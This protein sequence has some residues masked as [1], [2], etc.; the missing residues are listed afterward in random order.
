[1][2]ID[3]DKKKILDAFGFN[4]E[5]I[6]GEGER[7]LAIYK[8]EGTF[9]KALEVFFGEND[10]E[11]WRKLMAFKSVTEYF[12]SPAMAIPIAPTPELLLEIMRQ[13]APKNKNV[14]PDVDEYG[15][16]LVD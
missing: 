15:N 11:F 3:H 7:L 16:P 4:K 12:C 9:T 10:K 14:D 2:K 6:L 1:M 13:I 5:E 8:S